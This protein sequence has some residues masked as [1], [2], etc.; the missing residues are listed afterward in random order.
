MKK[1]KL[2]ETL[3][4]LDSKE[5][6][7]FQNYLAAAQTRKNSKAVQLLA[8]L[9]FN[10]VK[11]RENEVSYELLTTALFPE[12]PDDLQKL[13]EQMSILFKHLKKFLA[14][15]QTEEQTAYQQICFL[16]QLLKR[17]L[18]RVFEIHYKSIEASFNK[19]SIDDEHYHYY[20]YLLARVN[21]LYFMSKH[22]NKF[23]PNL[24]KMA[25]NFDIYF[26]SNKLKICCEL[27]N[28]KNMVKGDYE[29]RMLKEILSLLEIPN[30]PYMEIP[31]I[32]AYYLILKGLQSPQTETYWLQLIKLLP[33][34]V[35]ILKKIT[36]HELYNYVSNH[37]L[38]KN[39]KGESEHKETIFNIY[40]SMIDLD[41]MLIEE[42][43]SHADYKNIVII[44]LQL[45]KFDWVYKFIF[46]YKKAIPKE[47][48]ENAFTYS[49][50][51]YYYLTKE[52]EKALDLIRTVGSEDVYRFLSIKAL[53]IKIFYDTNQFEAIDY[54]IKSQTAYLHR[55]KKMSSKYRKSTLNLLRFINRIAKLKE[56]K[57]F[58]R[59]KKFQE[60]WQ[61]LNEKVKKTEPIVNKKWLLEIL[62]DLAGGSP[63]AI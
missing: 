10:L 40:K 43:I 38:S 1:N 33:K 14:L 24:Q 16:E 21:N 27:L 18:Y 61:R 44:G 26:I 30:Q 52:Y 63:L 62:N 31:I 48:Q 57:K 8:L 22:L 37:Y 59:K 51:A 25:D 50:S 17:G 54:L 29:I 15:L 58:I 35:G 7:R 4:T 2:V 36:L 47:H 34:Q 11:N 42:K 60:E 39:N 6:K 13:R 20:R 56:K 49:L 28:R 9:H 3:Q 23:D 12:K 41:I 45:K 5:W 55:N 32:K 46:D 19:I 53:Q